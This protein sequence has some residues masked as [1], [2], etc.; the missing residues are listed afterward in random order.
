M[1]LDEIELKFAEL[2]DKYN[3]SNI[4]DRSDYDNADKQMDEV[5]ENC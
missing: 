4:Q 2:I 5:G 1:K 3:K